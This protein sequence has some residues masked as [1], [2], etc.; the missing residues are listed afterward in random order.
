[1]QLARQHDPWEPFRFWLSLTVFVYAVRSLWASQWPGGIP[2][3]IL[4]SMV[5]ISLALAAKALLFP[6]RVVFYR[7]GNG[8]WFNELRNHWRLCC[9]RRRQ[10]Q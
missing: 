6:N 4:L 1:M 2:G 8:G 10:G 3:W 7:E 5:L 9:Q